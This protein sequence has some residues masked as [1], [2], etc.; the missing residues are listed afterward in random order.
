MRLIL[1]IFGFIFTTLTC[2]IV[3]LVFLSFCSRLLLPDYINFLIVQAILQPFVPNQNTNTILARSLTDTSPGLV[4]V[5][6][7]NKEIKFDFR[8]V[9]DWVR[10]CREQRSETPK[11]VNDVPS[12]S[13]VSLDPEGVIGNLN[14]QIAE[15]RL[16]WSYEGHRA[17]QSSKFF[18]FCA[19]ISGLI[20]TSLVGLGSSEFGRSARPLGRWITAGAIVSAAVGTAL[21]SITAYYAPADAASRSHFA[22]S[23]LRGLHGQMASEVRLTACSIS[24][25]TADQQFSAVDRMTEWGRRYR[26]IQA[27]IDSADRSGNP[28]P[29]SNLADTP[30]KP[31]SNPQGPQQ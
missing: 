22:A 27:S 14:G 15:S 4:D 20:T 3:L 12:A 18:M 19:V 13:Q 10:T 11:S 21:A 5:E 30:T 8:A 1:K 28:K 25:P 7:D 6:R 26:D 9:D 17:R 29:S 31:G 24:A 23:S 2:L 16:G